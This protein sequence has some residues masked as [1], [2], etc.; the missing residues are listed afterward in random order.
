VANYVKAT[1][2]AVKD[3]LL[4]G[5][6]SK[7]VKGTEIDTE[8]NAIASAIATKPDADSPTLTGTPLAPTASTA[9]NNT[10]IATTAYVVN[11][12]IQDIASKANLA[13]PTF[14]GTPAAP[15][16]AAGTNTTQLATT[17]FVHAE[18]SATVT[19]TNKTISVDDNTISGIAA[20]SFILSNASG[21][22]DGTA[23]QKAIPSGVVVG[24]T[25]TQTLTNKTISGSSNTITNIDAANISTGAL[26]SARITNALNA[27]GSA[28]LYACRAWV[29]FNGTS[30]VSIRSSGNVSS[31]TDNGTGD[32]TVNFTTAMPDV[33]YAISGSGQ[34]DTSSNDNNYVIMNIARVTSNPSTSSVQ[35]TTLTESAGPSKTDV[36]VATIMVVR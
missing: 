32:Y 30:T 29:N 26:A 27:T 35:I 23:S 36:L 13:S 34:F 21:H 31:I 2:F 6:P 7:L 25:D 12:I 11:R 18:R 28:P 1:N 33:N 4:T 10:Q 22:I 5:N 24:T 14:T 3:S 17:A 15:T 9:T 19:L 8:F 16:A 20:S